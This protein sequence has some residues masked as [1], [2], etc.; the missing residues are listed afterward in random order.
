MIHA[1]QKQYYNGGDKRKKG[2]KRKRTR[3]RLYEEKKLCETFSLNC[4]DDLPRPLT[5]RLDV[6]DEWHS[7]DRQ[8]TSERLLR[9][10]NIAILVEGLLD[11]EHAERRSASHP[12]DVS[13]DELAGAGAATETEHVPWVGDDAVGEERAVGREPAGG[14]ECLGLGVDSRVVQHRPGVGDDGGAL[15]DPVSTVLILLDVRMRDACAM[16]KHANRSEEWRSTYR[17][18]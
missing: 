10:D 9:L 17:Q 7:V 4:L 6:R 18:G 14:D 13:G 1:V 8:R 12:H 11:V 2:R 15:G 16:S 5:P 3:S